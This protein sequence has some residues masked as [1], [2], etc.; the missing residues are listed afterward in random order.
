MP[1]HERNAKN[2]CA[3]RGVLRIPTVRFG[4]FAPAWPGQILGLQPSAEA[5]PCG[6]CPEARPV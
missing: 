2:R 1:F 6:G 5:L 3:D 4:S